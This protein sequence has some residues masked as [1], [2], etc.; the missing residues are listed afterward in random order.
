MDPDNLAG[1]KET[2]TSVRRPGEAHTTTEGFLPLLRWN[3]P[4]SS[5]F[6]LQTRGEYRDPRRPPPLYDSPPPTIR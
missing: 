5:L 6:L 2:D 3:P 4:K 1:R